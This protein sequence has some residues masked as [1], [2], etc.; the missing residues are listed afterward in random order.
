MILIAHRGNIYGPNPARENS[1]V[2]IGEAL[3]KGFSV[4]V[5]V[6]YDGTDFWLGHDSPTYKIQES[7]LMNS[8]I[9]CHAKNLGSLQKMLTNHDIHCFWHQVDDYTVTSRGYIW[10]YPGKNVGKNTICVMPEATET[11]SLINSCLGIC[12]DFIEKYR[13]K[14]Y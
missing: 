8:N 10:A 4:E 11:P 12:S 7:F 2:Y 9:W 1:P 6:W 3:D 14:M 5:D 13:K